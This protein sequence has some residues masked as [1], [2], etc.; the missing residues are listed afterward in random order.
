MLAFERSL[1]VET[2]S[3][4]QLD[5]L[6]GNRP[7]QGVILQCSAISTTRIIGLGVV[8]ES[9]YVVNLTAKDTDMRTSTKIPLW[10]ALDQIVDPQNLGAI[11]RTSHFFGVDGVIITENE[12][13]PLTA[14]VS[15]ASSGALECMDMF[16]AGNMAKFL[17]V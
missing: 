15:K 12:S 6:S 1:P 14:I 7:H 4:A 2:C 17:E 11:L 8:D 13:A 9:K 5:K 3:R 16:T 10:L